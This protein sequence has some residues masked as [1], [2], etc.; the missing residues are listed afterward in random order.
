MSSNEAADGFAQVSISR[1]DAK[2]AHIKT[3]R[4]P[5]VVIGRGTVARINAGTVTL[6]VYLSRSV[7]TALKRLKHVTL[8]IRFSLVSASGEQL[9]STPPRTTSPAALIQHAGRRADG[10]LPSVSLRR[11]GRCE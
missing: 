9:R 8:T 4:S 5:S 1:R 10:E 6:H 2:R 7:A 11:D 3:G